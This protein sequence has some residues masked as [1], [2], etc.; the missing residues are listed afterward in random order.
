M[1][2]HELVPGEGYDPSSL[3]CRTRALPLDEPGKCWLR[4][5]ESN[6]LSLRYERN[7]IVLFHPSATEKLVRLEGVEPSLTVRE[8]AFLPLEDSLEYGVACGLRSRRLLLAKQ[9]LS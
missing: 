5:W 4:T 8:T 2:T 6:P 1:R 9:A 7:V 3:V